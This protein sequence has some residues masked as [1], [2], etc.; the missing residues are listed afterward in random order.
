MIKTEKQTFDGIE[1]SCTQFPATRGFRLLTNLVKQVGPVLTA[2][3]QLD[4]DLELGD[5]KNMGRLMPALSTGLASLDPEQAEKLMLEV[6]SSTSAIVS[7][8]GGRPITRQ[9]G[10]PSGQANVDRV[11]SGRMG[12]LLRVVAWALQVNF[13]DFSSGA[14]P[15]TPSETTQTGE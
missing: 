14:A 9:F 5:P 8:E 12:M 3:G 10:G 6:L 2:L 1:F 15:V 4:G 7:D 11:F 13:R